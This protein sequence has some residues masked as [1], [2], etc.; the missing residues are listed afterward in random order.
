MREDGRQRN[1]GVQSQLG[2][3]SAGCSYGSA[4]YQ[5]VTLRNVP[6]SLSECLPLSNELPGRATGSWGMLSSGFALHESWCGPSLGGVWIDGE[7]NL[8]YLNRAGRSNHVPSFG[9]N[10][11]TYAGRRGQEK[12]D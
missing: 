12:G 7:R 4:S 9:Q 1:G 8:E 11:E 6:V 5:T 10:K 2:F 3:N